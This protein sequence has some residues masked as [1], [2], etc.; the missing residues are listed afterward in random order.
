[1]YGRR[2]PDQA[3]PGAQAAGGGGG[4]AGVLDDRDGGSMS[5]I[6][7]LMRAI[8]PTPHAPEQGPGAREL[9]AAIMATPA[10][11]RRRSRLPQ[12]GAFGLRRPVLASAVPAAAVA[13]AIGVGLPAGGPATEF[14]NAAVSI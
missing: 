5:D 1:M 14:A 9:R 8:D 2:R 7:N 6:D 4:A 13:V 3:A 10:P 12:R 11:G